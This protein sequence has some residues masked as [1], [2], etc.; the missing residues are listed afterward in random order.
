VHVL[1]ADIVDSGALKAAAAATAHITGGA[2]DV[3]INN[4]ALVS[5]ESKGKTLAEA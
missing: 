4:A 1:A 2:L 3:L 5:E